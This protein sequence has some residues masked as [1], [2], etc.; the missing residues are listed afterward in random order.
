[1]SFLFHSP[2]KTDTSSSR[3]DDKNVD[4][5]HLETMIRLGRKYEINYFK[6]AALKHLRKLFPRTLSEWYGSQELIRSISNS[7]PQFL[8]GIINLA[9]E[10]QFQSIIPSALLSMCTIHDLVIRFRCCI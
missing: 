7:N 10:C 6:T 2:F 4:S 1:M 9:Y 3:L 5:S 8:F